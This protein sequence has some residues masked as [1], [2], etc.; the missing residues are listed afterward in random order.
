MHM[1]VLSPDGDAKF[2]LA[3][4]SELATAK[5]FRTVELSELQRIIEERQDEIMD[6][7]RWHFT[8]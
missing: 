1:H 4:G 7:W 8:A 3:P 2:W 6:L 5:G